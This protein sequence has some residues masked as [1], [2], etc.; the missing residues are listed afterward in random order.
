LSAP[1]VTSSS[2]ESLY[3]SCSSEEDM[4]L[5]TSSSPSSTPAQHRKFYMTRATLEV[6]LSIDLVL[7][8]AVVWRLVQYFHNDLPLNMIL[9][10]SNPRV[11]AACTFTKCDMSCT[12]TSENNCNYSYTPLGWPSSPGR[13]HYDH[14]KHSRGF[15]ER[16]YPWKHIERSILEGYY[17][18]SSQSDSTQ[19][20]KLAI[21]FCSELECCLQSK[22]KCL[23]FQMHVESI[24]PTS[25]KR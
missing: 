17:W 4:E 18:S 19:I 20:A 3:T 8:S 2:E 22:D 24:S 11:P 13:V 6:S 25:I 15:E 12:G 9:S 10:N 23:P 7:N 16:R 1:S 21:E 14:S 5:A